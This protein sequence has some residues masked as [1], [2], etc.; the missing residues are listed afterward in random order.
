MFFNKTYEER[1]RIW[2][3]FRQVL[4]SAEDPFQEAMDTYETVPTE[5]MSVDPYTPSAW[6]NPWELIKEN[7]YCLFGKMLGIAY[8]LQL[9]ERFSQ[10][11]F[12]IH[13]FIDRAKSNHYYLL[14]VGEVVIG[15]E[16]QLKITRQTFPKDLQ[17]QMQYSM[18]ALN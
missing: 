15:Y 17:P 4:E 1:L 3:D 7:S 2:H 5:H 8:S 18:P 6:P 10:E 16:N 14:N 12:E 9:T 11:E 13:I